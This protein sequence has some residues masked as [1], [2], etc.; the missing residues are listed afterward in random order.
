MQQTTGA[1]AVARALAEAG[2]QWV[3]SLSGNQILD[4]Y[5]ALLD[6][7]I[8]LIHTR[9]EA[10]AGHMADAWGRLTGQPGVFL[11]TAGPGHANGAVAAGV[12]GAAESPLL[13][14]SG[15]SPLAQAGRGAFQEQDQVGLAT[16]VCKAAWCA[17]DPQTLPQLI[18]AALNLA[19]ADP[20]RPGACHHPYRYSSRNDSRGDGC[21]S[22]PAPGG[23]ARRG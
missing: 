2:V 18:A 20:T 5:D 6:T 9:H 23:D 11:V 3:F 19:A 16:P 7:G 13:W 8:K 1:N 12:A 15:G 22:R 17:S 14:L 4:L 10:A 21:D